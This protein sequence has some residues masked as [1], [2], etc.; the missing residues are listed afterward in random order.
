MTTVTN[1]QFAIVSSGLM[2]ADSARNHY[3]DE[4]KSAVDTMLK[5]VVNT[6]DLRTGLE[7]VFSS[8]GGEPVVRYGGDRLIRVGLSYKNPVG[9]EYRELSPLAFAMMNA[10]RITGRWSLAIPE[11][12]V[13]RR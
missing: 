11:N 8:V 13:Y 2:R 4:A 3:Y 1:Q 9:G 12:I 5:Q 6:L 10:E 7:I